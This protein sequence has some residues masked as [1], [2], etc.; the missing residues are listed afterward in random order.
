MACLFY[1]SVHGIH[2][3]YSEDGRRIGVQAD[4]EDVTVPVVAAE[5]RYQT[6]CH[7]VSVREGRN[8][9]LQTALVV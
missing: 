9:R 7:K 3:C 5:L 2:K 4:G 6:V 1:D 8:H